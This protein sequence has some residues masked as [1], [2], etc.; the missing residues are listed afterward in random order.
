MLKNFKPKYL[1]WNFLVSGQ[2]YIYKFKEDLMGIL[3]STQP[4]CL[5]PSGSNIELYRSIDIFFAT[6]YSHVHA[7]PFLTPNRDFED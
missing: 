5:C 4:S 3:L 1:I 7:T 6:T 2:K